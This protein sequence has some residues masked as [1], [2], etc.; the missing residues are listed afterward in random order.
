MKSVTPSDQSLFIWSLSV[1]IGPVVGTLTIDYISLR[2]VWWLQVLVFCL[3]ALL[4]FPIILYCVWQHRRV[5]PIHIS[6]MDAVR[7]KVAWWDLKFRGCRCRVC[8]SAEI[9]GWR[10]RRRT[11]SLFD[12]IYS[13]WLWCKNWQNNN[14]WLLVCWQTINHHE[15]SSVLNVRNRFVTVQLM[16]KKA[17]DHF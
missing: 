13:F 4:C 11:W 15:D 3:P 6:T 7:I 8:E 2:D 12:L 5:E 17:F 1:W 16:S 9:K 10:E 14:L